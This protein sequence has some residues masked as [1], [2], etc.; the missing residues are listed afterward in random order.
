RYS[1]DE[2]SMFLLDFKEGVSFTEFTPTELDPSWVPHARSV[3]IESDREYGVAVLR[4]LV[5]E[6]SRRSTTL[7]RAGVSKLADLRRRKGD[8]AMPRILTV[9]DEFHVLFAGNDGLA[10]EAVAL[11][12]ELA[13]KGRS[14]GVHLILASQT[15]SGIEALYTKTESIF[16]QFPMRIA[17]AGG[18]N[19]LDTLNNGADGLPIGAAVINDAGGIVGHNRTVRFPNA[20]AEE[21]TLAQ[22]RQWMW[23]SRQPG[24]APPAVFQGFAEQEVTDDPTYLSLRPGA[25]HRSL[26]V[27]RQIDVVSSTA[28]FGL[29]ATPGRHLA[30]LGPSPSGADILHASIAG[31]ACQH[32][33][34]SARFIVASLV[35][36]AEDV[37]ESAADAVRSSGH[38]AEEVEAPGLLSLLEKL[39]EDGSAASDGPAHTY[40]TVFGMDAAAGVLSQRLGNSPGVTGRTRFRDIL[41]QGPARG[42][43][44]LGWWRGIQRFSEDIG[45]SSM[46]EDLACLVALNVSAQSL[47][48]HIGKLNLQW[49]PR[50]NRAL[51]ID[52]HNDRVQ[53]IV[54]FVRSDRHPEGGSW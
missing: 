54:P 11:L 7:K 10:R 3:G 20:H 2:L 18:G 49:E 45:G 53:P 28:R 41:K 13:R 37:A 27:G 42:V 21:E 48:S 19:V 39:S 32:S 15:A 29:D 6:M 33:P 38:A 43:H 14:Y 46:R 9:I 4:E 24:A 12:E 23:H 31:L 26:L 30:V 47:G 52:L 35:D 16:G 17:L 50:A 1:P 40:L 22:V 5:A 44:L 51:L 34:G 25:R 8:V 36:A